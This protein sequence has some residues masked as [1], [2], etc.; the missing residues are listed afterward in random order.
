MGPGDFRRVPGGLMG[1]SSSAWRPQER[2]RG[3]HEVKGAFQEVTGGS[4][5]SEGLSGAFQEIC[6]GDCGNSNGDSF[7]L[8]QN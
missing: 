5:W 4:R 3:C 8:F 2:F 7:H 1:I 6:C